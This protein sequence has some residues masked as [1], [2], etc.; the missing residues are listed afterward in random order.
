MTDSNLVLTG[1]TPQ[2]ILLGTSNSF[3]VQNLSE[4]RDVYFKIKDSNVA[5]GGKI[6][7][8]QSFSFASDITFTLDTADTS[9]TST[10]YVIRD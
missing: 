4:Y 6:K 8:N 5:I 3:I 2:N 10:L 9:A 1:T 7:P